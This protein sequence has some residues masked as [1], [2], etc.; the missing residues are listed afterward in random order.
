MSQETFNVYPRNI[1]DL[2]EI[3]RSRISPSARTNFKFKAPAAMTMVPITTWFTGWISQELGGPPVDM[4]GIDFENGHPHIQRLL[5]NHNLWV[6][7][8]V[9]YISLI[10]HLC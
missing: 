6:K 10:S 3:V 1:S 2:R 5:L 4:N 9:L 8:C 7:M